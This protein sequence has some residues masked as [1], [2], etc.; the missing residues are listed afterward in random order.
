M[1][2]GDTDDPAGWLTAVELGI[3]E[4]VASR[5][6]LRALLDAIEAGGGRLTVTVT[7][8]GSGAAGATERGGLANMR[9]RAAR[10]RGS[11][12]VRAAE[13]AG[14]AICWSVPI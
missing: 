1:A 14:T 12:E 4:V 2:H 7:D 11:F 6:R 13:P 9:Q 8:N 3:G 5:E 10:H